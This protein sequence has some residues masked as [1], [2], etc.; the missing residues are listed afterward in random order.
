M[1]RHVKS[2]RCQSLILFASI[3]Q[4]WTK[5]NFFSKKKNTLSL[6]DKLLPVLQTQG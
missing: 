1:F 5:F 2:C 4:S 6:E 3:F